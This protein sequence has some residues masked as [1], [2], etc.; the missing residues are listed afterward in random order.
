[1]NQFPVAQLLGLQQ[2]AEVVQLCRRHQHP[3]LGTNQ[4]IKLPEVKILGGL[5]QLAQEV[6][7]LLAVLLH[8][9]EF[10]AAEFVCERSQK[11]VYVS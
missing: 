8:G 9:V 2:L 11:L 3:C 10:V 6:H 1:M 4:T 5:L 7:L